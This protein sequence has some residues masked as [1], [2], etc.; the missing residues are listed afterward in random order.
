MTLGPL[1]K[2]RISLFQLLMLI[3]LSSEPKYGYEILKEL[4]EHFGTTWIP[5]TGTIYPAL[6]SLEKRGFIKTSFKDGKEFYILT[7]KGLSIMNSLLENIENEISFSNKYFE[8]IHQNLSV[9]IKERIID[10]INK[11]VK[12]N[13]FLMGVLKIFSDDDIDKKIRLNALYGLRNIL[14]E[15]LEYV[16]NI[17]LQLEGNDYGLHR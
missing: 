8:F 3:Q 7:E 15:R 10:I 16:T 12:E 17:I 2:A 11:M 5:K 6:R 14:Q 1:K 13:I 4:K 9:S